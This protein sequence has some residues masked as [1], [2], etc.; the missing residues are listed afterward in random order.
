MFASLKEKWSEAIKNWGPQDEHDKA[1]ADL[2]ERATS[3]LLISAD[4]GLNMEIV[5]MIN[6]NPTVME[7]KT[8]RVLRRSLLKSNA[9]VQMLALTVSSFFNTSLL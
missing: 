9:K 2:V 4:W 1:I 8:L 3:E 5:D 7:E 6:R